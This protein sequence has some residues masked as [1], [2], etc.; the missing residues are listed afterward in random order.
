VSG[1]SLAGRFRRGEPD[2]VSATVALVGKAVRYRGHTIPFDERPD[3][4][5][6][7]IVALVAAVKG[8]SFADDDAFNGFVRMVAYRRCI[9]WTRQ[10][11][12]KARLDPP[13]REVVEAEK[14]LHAK[15]RRKLAVEILAQLKRPC[16]ELL[17]LRIGRG[18]TYDQ[19]AQLL[20][21]S[22]GALRTQVHYCLKKARAILQRRRRRQKLFR[23]ADWRRR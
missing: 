2:A 13:V 1:D 9:D 23:L 19:M 21:R 10:A 14:R 22:E 16:R 17:S 18:L 12:R 5:Q 20:G 6:D 8:R 11:M 4:I 3:V 7:A 15:D